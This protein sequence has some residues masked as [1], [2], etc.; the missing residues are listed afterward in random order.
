[1]PT[2]TESLPFQLVTKGGEF[3]GFLQGGGVELIVSAFVKEKKKG[4]F[5]RRHCN[6]TE[7]HQMFFPLLP[8]LNCNGGKPTINYW[9]C[10]AS[11][12]TKRS[13]FE[14]LNSFLMNE[15]VRMVI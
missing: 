10:I 8:P 1:M 2:A 3:F 13:V 14:L 15:T 5:R 12:L 9:N 11:S 7:I 6:S 4:S